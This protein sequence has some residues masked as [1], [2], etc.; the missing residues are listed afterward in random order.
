MAETLLYYS[1]SAEC[2]K[3]TTA[4]LMRTVT[5]CNYSY[6]NVGEARACQ[7]ER[8]VMGSKYASWPGHTRPMKLLHTGTLS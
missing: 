7:Q 2:N 6:K 4:S 3:G 1:L 5:E 8:H